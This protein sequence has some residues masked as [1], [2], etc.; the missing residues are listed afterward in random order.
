[1]E[2][3]VAIVGG[4]IVGLAHAWA[5]AKRGLRVL[6]F[7]RGAQATG[8]TV[9][10]FGMIWP[11]GQPAGDAYA[12]ALHSARLWRQLA[13]QAG[14]WLNSCGSLHLAHRADEWRVLEEFAQL[15]PQ[16][17]YAGRIVTSDEALKLAPAA[18]PDGLLGGWLSPN[19]LGVNPRR[20]AAQI[21]GWLAEQL[22]VSFHFRTTIVDVDDGMLRAADGR[23]WRA[24]RVMICSGA[25]FETLFPETLANSGLRPCKLQ[26]LR[27]ASQPEGWRIGPHLASGL[28]LRHYHNFAICAGLEELKRRVAHETPELDHFG[29]HVMASQNELGEVILG[30]SHEYGER[31]EPFDKSVIDD[32]MLRELQSIIRLPHW[33]ITERWHGIYAKH[34][35]QSIFRAEP[36]A[37]VYVRTGT[38]GS[39]MTM[40]FGLAEQDW[41]QWEGPCQEILE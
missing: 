24:T 25:D 40:S 19:E 16:L 18:N 29:I 4:G 10:N 9:R 35:S 39:G 27:T 5:A 37:G 7:E 34:P 23:R 38:G 26:M 8:A 14:F 6:L 41:E 30:D 31:I 15:A 28:T 36:Q 17:G 11:I 1:M 20:A 13:P 32:L 3:D 12:T 22:R 21:A 2:S 33:Q